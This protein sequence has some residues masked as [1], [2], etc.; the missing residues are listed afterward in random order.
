MAE[1]IRA[2]SVAPD[3]DAIPGLSVQWVLNKHTVGTQKLTSGRT[4]MA[5]GVRSRLHYHSNAEAV[6]FILKGRVK[7]IIGEQRE[8]H[9]VEPGCFCFYRMGEIHGQENVGDETAEWIFC[10]AGA[11]DVKEADTV[12]VE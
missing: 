9:V 1:F 8:E 4:T 5:P 7:I 10:Y 3:A 11:P 2:E 6:M 12:F